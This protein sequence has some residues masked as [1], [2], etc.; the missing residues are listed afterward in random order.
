[1]V[2][3]DGTITGYHKLSCAIT[4][5]GLNCIVPGDTGYNLNQLIAYDLNGGSLGIASAQDPS[6]GYDAVTLLA[7]AL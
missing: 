3:I 5:S 4:N 7:I 6:L 2:F 1:M